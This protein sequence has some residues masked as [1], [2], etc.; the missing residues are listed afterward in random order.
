[1]TARS[2]T[3][4]VD[5]CGRPLGTNKVHDLP[6]VARTAARQPWAVATEQI[7]RKRKIPRME[8]IALTVQARY[9]TLQWWLD[10]DGAAPTV[11]GILDGLVRAKV[12][13][14]DCYPHIAKITYLRPTLDRTQP[15]AMVVRVEEA[16]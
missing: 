8:C 11:K 16:E 3:F 5:T 7:A 15:P 9:E 10:I 4:A 2:W 12:V 13:P 14:D 6:G 1:V